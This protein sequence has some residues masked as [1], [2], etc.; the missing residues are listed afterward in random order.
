[1]S[2]KAQIT[3]SEFLS[4]FP[5]IDKRATFVRLDSESVAVEEA[6]AALA[7]LGIDAKWC[8]EAWVTPSKIELA[9]LQADPDGRVTIDGDAAAKYT[10]ELEWPTS[11]GAA[12]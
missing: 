1:M 7:A 2:S 12:T 5:L 9:M 6:T 10:I 11:W 3:R 8:T 4:H